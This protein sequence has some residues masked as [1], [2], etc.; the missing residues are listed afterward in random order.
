MVYLIQSSLKLCPSRRALRRVRIDIIE[1]FKGGNIDRS[2]IRRALRRVRRHIDGYS[3]L[4]ALNVLD[5]NTADF[6]GL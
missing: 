2:I 6:Y 5:A 1:I 4:K 3:S